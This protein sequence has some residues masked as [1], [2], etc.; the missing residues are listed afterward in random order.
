[1]T[2][3]AH[4]PRGSAGRDREF[5]PPH[6]LLLLA[7]RLMRILGAVVQ[8]SMLPM[9]HPGQELMHGRPVAFQFVR[10]DHPRHIG[11]PFQE[12]AEES[13]RCLLVATALDENIQDIAIL[14][15]GPP[16]VVAF[17]MDGQKD[18][19]PVPLITGSGAPP[20]E[21]IGIGLPKF[22][23]PIPHR[24]IGQDYTALGHQ[25]FDVPV[26]EAKAKVRSQTQ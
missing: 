9:F 24:F 18:L 1:M 16:Q 21:P 10:D 5:K 8:V 25:L 3:S 4:R 17:A 19:V 26:A 15:D 2:Q 13:L 7:G 20:T 12:L 11:Q 14:V 6:A 23:A 22:P